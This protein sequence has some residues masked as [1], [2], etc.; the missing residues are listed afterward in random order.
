[1]AQ[2]WVQEVYKMLKDGTNCTKNFNYCKIKFVRKTFQ[3]SEEFCITHYQN[4]SQKITVFVQSKKTCLFGS[5]PNF[6]SYSKFVN[7]LKFA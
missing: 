5:S 6:A 7:Y 2:S 4:I 3:G 1:M